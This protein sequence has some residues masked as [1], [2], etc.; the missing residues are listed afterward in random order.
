MADLSG[1]TGAW[2]RYE[3]TI[4]KENTGDTMGKDDFLKLLVAQLTHQD[5]TNPMQDTEF[6][7]QLAQYSGLE[8]QMNMNTNL[9]KLIASNNATTTAAAV[10]L[11]GT[12]V[13]YTGEDG[14]LK[15]GL[16]TF[17]DI[18]AGQV[19]LY[20]HDG[21]YIPFSS[22]EQIGIMADSGT[23]T[24]ET[25]TGTVTPPTDDGTTDDDGDDSDGGTMDELPGGEEEDEG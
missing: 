25:G 23:G 2:T 1:I 10:S 5:P 15:T 3:D 12:V 9:E 22:V 8:Q 21:S 6:V 4:K 16:V 20:L 11:I 13:G 24:D 17:L 18:V 19:N 14:T 7:T